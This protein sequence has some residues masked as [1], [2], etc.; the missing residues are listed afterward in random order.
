MFNLLDNKAF[1]FVNK[2]VNKKFN[3]LEY[4]C[5]LLMVCWKDF[6][7]I[8]FEIIFDCSEIELIAETI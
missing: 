2:I 5:L 4:L 8:L 6:K 7:K 3:S 1:N